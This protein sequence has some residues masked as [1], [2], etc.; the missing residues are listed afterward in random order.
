MS[1]TEDLIHAVLLG[2]ASS[3]S[4]ALFKEKFESGKS[5]RRP[6]PGPTRCSAAGRS[7]R[8]LPAVGMS[9]HG[10][11][12]SPPPGITLV[13]PPLPHSQNSAL[14]LLLPGSRLIAARAD[15]E[16]LF[17][18]RVAQSGAELN[19]INLPLCF[20]WFLISQQRSPKYLT[21]V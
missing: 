15:A 19:K 11:G 13:P 9:I 20:K 16:M 5:R 3:S 14:P 10:P 18:T 1:I 12:A 4:G 2:G 7:P 21:R 17:C 8:F 6:W